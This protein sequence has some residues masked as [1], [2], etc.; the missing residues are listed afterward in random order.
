VI[1]TRTTR[2]AAAGSLS[3]PGPD[4]SPLSARPDK[5]L[6]ARALRSRFVDVLGFRMYVREAGAGEPILL[7]HGLGVSGRYF[8]PLARVLA[9]RRHVIVPDLPGWGRSERPLRPL[10][11]GGGADVLAAFLDRSGHAALPI[12]ANSFGCQVALRLAQRRPDL[13]GPLVL[14]GPTVDPRYRTWWLHA[15][16]LTLDSIRERPALWRILI[17]DY[18][19]MGF[20]RFARAA[21]AALEDR[22]EDRISSLGPPVIVVRGERDAI[23]TREWAS[24]CASL[25]PHGSFATVRNAAHAAHFSHRLAVAGLVESFL[26]EHPHRLGELIG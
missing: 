4:L 25:A 12:V 17:G 14:L 22:P 18:A 1:L 16:R 2:W 15:V 8:M 23:A 5:E 13:V 7:L 10:G 9:E 21:R 20:R 19:R 3:R 11:V 6:Q 26:A 24:E